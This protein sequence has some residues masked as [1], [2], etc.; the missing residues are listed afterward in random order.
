M[1]L[2]IG[3]QIVELTDPA[4][5]RLERAAKKAQVRIRRR[6]MTPPPAGAK[7]EDN[8]FVVGTRAER[9]RG[10]IEVRAEFQR[11]FRDIAED[12][13]ELNRYFDDLDF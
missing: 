3:N 1:L 6:R 4:T 13:E 7:E 12:V 9:R 8:V 11:H 10:K 5:M 2:E